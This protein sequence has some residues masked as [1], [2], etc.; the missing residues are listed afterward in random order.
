MATTLNEA[1]AARIA[2]RNGYDPAR[3]V[4]IE[5]EGNSIYAAAVR[6]GDVWVI[7]DRS[8]RVVAVEGKFGGTTIAYAAPAKDPVLDLRDEVRALEEAVALE[9][10]RK[11]GRLRAILRRLR[12]LK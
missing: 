11:L 8:L 4:K 2:D 5:I 10:L 12:L 7:D 6:A 1:E 9:V 3:L